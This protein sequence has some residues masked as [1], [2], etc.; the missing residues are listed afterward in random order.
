M[1]TKRAEYGESEDGTDERETSDDA[2]DPAPFG[3]GA[4]IFRKE[5]HGAERNEVELDEK[6]AVFP[7]GGGLGGG[8]WLGGSLGRTPEFEEN[9]EESDENDGPR[10][11][12]IALAVNGELIGAVPLV[13]RRVGPVALEFRMMNGDPMN[14]IEGDER[15][16]GKDESRPTFQ[17]RPNEA[18]GANAEN[19]KDAEWMREVND[20]KEK[21]GGD[22]AATFCRPEE[23]ECETAQADGEVVVHVAHV[24]NVAVGKHGDERSEEPG[25][26]ARGGVHEG[27]DSPEESENAEG[28]SKFFGE[29]EAD[30]FGEIVEDE[31]EE[32]VVPLPGEIETGGFALVDEFGEPGVVGVAA[33]IAGLN[34]GVPEAGDEEKDGYER[35]EKNG[36][37]RDRCHCDEDSIARMGG[38]WPVSD[39]R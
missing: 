33:E 34:V 32:D 36:A 1:R 25:R 14:R 8:R 7:I 31:I 5:R 10:K 2:A 16:G 22:N 4:D 35:E 27:E 23:G 26:A 21:R 37:A 38:E 15:N 19:K 24:E 39:D 11:I 29:G 18:I 12:D 28:D 17:E 3:D 13:E 30:A 6:P 9:S 20:G